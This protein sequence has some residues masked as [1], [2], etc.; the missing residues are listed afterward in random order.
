MRQI[1]SDIQSIY[2]RLPAD[3][4]LR[5]S[6]KGANHFT[7][8]DDGALL[9][10]GIFRGLL[11]VFGKFRIDGRRQLAITAYCVRS[12]FDTYLKGQPPGIRFEDY[13]EIRVEH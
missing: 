8:T 9:K 2:E 3:G 4:R 12:F 11:R 10:S 5:V 13:P 7:F 1:Q 6:I